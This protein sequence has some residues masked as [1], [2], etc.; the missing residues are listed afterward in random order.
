MRIAYLHGFNSGGASVKGRQLGEAITALP[1]GVRPG[2]FLPT[3]DHE[4]RKAVRALCEWTEA[5]ADVPV[6]VGSSLGGFYAIHLAERYGA[7]GVLINPALEPHRSLAPYLGPQRNPYTGGSYEL[8]AGH[9]AQLEA[10]LVARITRPERYFLLVQA[11]D[12]LL[13]YRVA[14]ARLAGGWQFVQG[15]GDH[16]Y[17][18]FAL[19]IPA[20]LRFAGVDLPAAGDRR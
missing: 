16:A 19:Q 2:Y 3:L 17:R 8:T 5:R 4:P 20:V 1:A 14:V 15:G 11:G 9:L 10:L 7:K 12:E 6:Y 18:D 13:D